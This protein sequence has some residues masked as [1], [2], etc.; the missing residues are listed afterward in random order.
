MTSPNPSGVTVV[1]PGY[2]D[3]HNAGIFQF[4]SVVAQIPSAGIAL[5]NGIQT[6]LT[7]FVPNDGRNH[8]FLLMGM[9]N[10]SSAET[11]GAIQVAYSTP[12]TGAVTG[13]PDAGGNASTGPNGWNVVWRFATP[14][15]L[16]TVTQSSALTAGGAIAYCQLWMF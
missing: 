16:I 13:T 7:Y 6:L 10:V 9:T 11:G 14:G 4:P 8:V 12:V 1:P 15:S 3:P 2:N 5:I